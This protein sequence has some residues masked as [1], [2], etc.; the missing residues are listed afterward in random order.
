MKLLLTK[1]NKQVRRSNKRSKPIKQTLWNL[2]CQKI[3][4]Q[5]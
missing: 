1:N 3:I 4:H 2:I 5:L